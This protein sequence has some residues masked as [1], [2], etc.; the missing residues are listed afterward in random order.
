MTVADILGLVLLL[1]VLT[2]V[3]VVGFFGRPRQ[4]LSR[5][6]RAL[7]RAGGG[8]I[9]IGGWLED[10][11]KGDLIGPRRETVRRIVYLFEEVATVFNRQSRDTTRTD[12]FDQLNKAGKML[13]G[14]GSTV[15]ANALCELVETSV[16]EHRDF[17]NAGRALVM[18]VAGILIQGGIILGI[19]MWLDALT[20]FDYL[21][22]ELLG[23]KTITLLGVVISGVIGSLA[24]AVFDA[25]AGK[26]IPA[27]FLELFVTAFSRPMLGAILVLFVYLLFLS[28]VI[29]NPFPSVGESVPDKLNRGDFFLIGIAF[30]VG[31]NDTL[32]LNLSGRISGFLTPDRG[33]RREG[34]EEPE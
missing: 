14:T 12:L 15:P 5:A 10:L 24:R 3:V 28:D 2:T 23:I 4:E 11:A 19:F 26:N 16:N 30:A 17:D 22:D 25:R 8:Q 34:T 33:R 29:G 13:T 27:N 20:D 6:S 21:K 1:L 31:F 32:G 7:T 9:Q 18:L